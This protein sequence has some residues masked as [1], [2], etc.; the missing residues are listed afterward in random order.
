MDLED[1]E[2]V[3]RLKSR[4]TH[5]DGIALPPASA[6]RR[7]GEMDAIIFTEYIRC[8]LSKHY[9]AALPRGEKMIEGME[10]ATH[11]KCATFECLALS[12]RKWRQATAT[13]ATKTVRL[14]HDDSHR[15]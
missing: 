9:P 3:R 1:S 13:T 12:P 10:I 4:T 15:N 11:R 2:L 5:S 8:H 6:R 7:V 14:E